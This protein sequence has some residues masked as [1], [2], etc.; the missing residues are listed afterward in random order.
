MDLVGIFHMVEM[1]SSGKHAFN[2]INV[3]GLI[4]SIIQFYIKIV[5]KLLTTG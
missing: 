2:H 4:E 3:V 1:P 5:F